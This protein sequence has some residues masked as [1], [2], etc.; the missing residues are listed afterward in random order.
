MSDDLEREEGVSTHLDAPSPRSSLTLADIGARDIVPLVTEELAPEQLDALVME[1]DVDRIPPFVVRLREL[2]HRANAI[3]ERLE[4]RWAHETG[5]LG[6]ADP[7]SE[8]VWTFRGSTTRRW[9]DLGALLAG[10]VQEGLSL[11]TIGE[12]ITEMRVTDL[13]EA[14]RLFQ[15]AKE[16]R[17][18]ELLEQHRGPHHGVPHFRELED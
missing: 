8:R 12:A 18:V 10:L 7:G 1:L 16:K 6:W 3:A 13:R 5:G 14:A 2:A 17:I 9:R 15:P 11:R 4:L